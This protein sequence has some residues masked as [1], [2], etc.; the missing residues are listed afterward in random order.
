MNLMVVSGMTWYVVMIMLWIESCTWTQMLIT[1]T[2]VHSTSGG[3]K[4]KMNTGL[5]VIAITVSNK[6]CCILSLLSSS[7]YF[8]LFRCF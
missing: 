8:I 6:R 7:K 1:K 5:T 3:G 4:Y 2:N